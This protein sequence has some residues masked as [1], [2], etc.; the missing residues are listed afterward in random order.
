MTSSMAAE[1]AEIPSVLAD[2]VARRAAIAELAGRLDVRKAP[3]VMLCGRG[4]SGHATTHLRYLVETRLGIPVSDVAPSVVT[5]FGADLKLAG[6]LFVVISQSGKSPDLVVATKAARTAGAQTVAIVNDAQSAVALAA[7][8][9]IPLNAGREHSVAATKSVAASMFAGAELVAALAGDSGLQS[10][11]ARM[12]GRTASALRLDWATVGEALRTARCFYVTSRGFGLGVAQEIAL[13]CAETLRLPALAYSA[14][15]LL[16]GPR[17][18]VTATTPVLALR[19][20]DA[21]AA[22]VDALSRNLLA[23]DVPLFLAGG[24][25]SRLPWIGDDHPATDAISMLVPA[26]LMIER[27]ARAMGYDPDRPPHLSKVTETL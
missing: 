8:H 22:S 9:M 24:P 10:A 27:A 16:H 3:V 20:E 6:A 1:T 5:A 11:L 23:S 13:K 19:L 2:I 12:P 21:T 25:A 14:A 26:Y 17:A 7:E 15:E 18:A 4:S